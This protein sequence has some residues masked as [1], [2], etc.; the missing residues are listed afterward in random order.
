MRASTYIVATPCHL[1]FTLLHQKLKQGDIIVLINKNGVFDIF[2]DYVSLFSNKYDI[3]YIE[4]RNEM[5][6]RDSISLTW[7]GRRFFKNNVDIKL[8]ENSFLNKRMDSVYVFN[9]S[10]LFTQ[11]I[12]RQL[13]Y[14]ELVYIEDGSAPYNEHKLNRS[15]SRVILKRLF[16]GFDYDFLKVIGTSR[17]INR[18]LFSFPNFVRDENKNKP[19]EKLKFSNSNKDVCSSVSNDM[20]N[21]TSSIDEP[22]TVILCPLMETVDNNEELLSI[23]VGLVEKEVL[24]SSVWIKFHP[25]EPSVVR[26]RFNDIPNIVLLPQ[27][28]PAEMIL[29]SNYKINKLIGFNTSALYTVYA[30]GLNEVIAVENY[31]FAANDKYIDFLDSLGVS[32]YEV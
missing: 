21:L 28:I 23:T 4:E 14:K 3:C 6:L 1:I 17:Y 18:S 15:F 20:I 29:L 30:L 5:S 8:E 19:V 2:H 13:S 7:F 32:N 12:I 11:Y 26:E 27:G 31:H 25:R 16:F 10:P 22:I 9:D 24:R